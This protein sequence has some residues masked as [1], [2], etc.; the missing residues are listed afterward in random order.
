MYPN[1]LKFI[2]QLIHEGTIPGA[3][4]NIIDQN[5]MMQKALGSRQVLPVKEEMTSDTLFDIASLTKV[6][7]TTT[8]IL[9]LI[10]NNHVAPTDTL[11]QH[12]TEFHDDS[13]TIQQLLTHTSGIN[14]FIPNRD[15]L[16][17]DEL[18]SAYMK[19]P[20]DKEKQNAEVVYTDTGTILLG[21]MI[22]KH[23]QKPIQEV[24]QA[25]V[26]VP[27]N[28]KQ[29]TFHP[30]EHSLPIA[31][32]EYSFARGLIKGEV[33]DP[34]AACL[35]ERCG[36]AGLFS[37]IRDLTNFVSMLFANGKTQ[38]HQRFLNAQTLRLLTKNWNDDHLKPRTLGWDLLPTN[39]QTHAL[40]H[41][42][43]TGTFMIVDL[44]TKQAFIFLSNRVHPLDNRPLYIARR[45]E[46]I[47]TYLSE[48]N[49]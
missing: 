30:Q 19:L 34:K 11:K 7:G 22:E 24:I 14:S 46:L 38:N 35:Q 10:E 39:N 36:S 6:V 1:T 13:V 9:K 25:E 45:D 12:L 41:T 26:L 31:P 27:L 49:Q 8:V 40:F 3:V 29:S 15:S 44:E 20:I 23:Y 47:A 4:F 16:T 5:R 2:Q 21:L 43:Y 33:H 48:K 37:T 28:M 18:I 17:A 42:G 32:T